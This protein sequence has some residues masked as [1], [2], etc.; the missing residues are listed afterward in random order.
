MVHSRGCPRTAFFMEIHK[1][2][3]L[4]GCTVLILTF[5]IFS[6]HNSQTVS[7]LTDSATNTVETK[8]SVVKNE[9]KPSSL[10]SPQS[11]TITY[12]SALS[13]LPT[14]RLSINT[15][16]YVGSTSNSKVDRSTTPFPGPVQPPI[17][18]SGIKG[19]ITIGPTCPVLRA[20]ADGNIESGCKDRPYSTEIIVK[21]EDGLREVAR[22]TS[23]KDGLYYIELAPGVY[24]VTA[25][26]QDGFL[27]PSQVSQTITV[28]ESTTTQVSFSLDSGIR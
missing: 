8:T 11:E 6:V 25:G 20:D 10:V 5:G 1:T 26:P 13:S 15:D 7:V 2:V 19:Q 18:L 3:I 12:S 14:Q 16:N 17:S 4:L 21:T 9:Q 22:T 23:G 24:I 27:F 28:V